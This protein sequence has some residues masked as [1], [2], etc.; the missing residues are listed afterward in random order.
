[1]RRITLDDGLYISYRSYTKFADYP[2]LSELKIFNFNGEIASRYFIVESPFRHIF[3]QQITHLILVFENNFNEISCK[4]CTTDSFPPLILRD[5][6]L[7]TCYSST[8]YKLCIHVMY[9]DDVFALLDGRLNQLNTLN[10][11]IINEEC[12]ATN[13]YKMNNLPDLKC[14][15]LQYDC[16]SDIYD[17]QILPLLRRMSNI[18]SLNLYL[19][20]DNQT[21][22]IDGEH[23]YNEIIVHM[24]QLQTLNFCFCTFIQFDYLVHH[25]FK[26]DIL[27]TF[28]NIMCQQVDCMI[29]YRR[30]DVKYHVFSLT[31]MFDYL[32]LIDNIFPNIIFNHVIRLMS[33]P[34]L[35]EL[36]VFNLMSQSSIS[37]K[38]NSNDNQLHSTITEY[39]YLT[40]LNLGFV[41]HDYIDQFLND[42]KHI[43]L[44]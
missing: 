3:Q 35:K 32:P 12:N 1:M 17:S 30:Y 9:Y 44:A 24:S 36:H 16:L 2:N 19:T 38:L 31:F 5:L 22:F 6:P 28:S 34:L 42:K 10:V 23:I 39:P 25:L 8:I 40:L 43:Y 11:V 14:F 20:I 29:N 4:H 21:T 33:F 7:T 13:V 27:Q 37:N 18:E 15:Y 41:H 26:D